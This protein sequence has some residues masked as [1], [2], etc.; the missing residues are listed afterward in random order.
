MWLRPFCLGHHLLFKRLALPF[1]EAPIA[2]SGIDNIMVG[3]L[4]CSGQSYEW[5]R[6][7]FLSGK[8]SLFVDRLSRGLCG[9]WYARKKVDLRE[10]EDLFRAYLTDGYSRPPL[11]HYESRNG[12]QLT[13]PWEVL[14]K[15]RLVQAGFSESEVL[16]G[17]LPARWYDFFT[18]KELRQLDLCSD[19]SRWRRTFFTQAEYQ[20]MH[21]EDQ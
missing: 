12:V 4:I 14:L 2:A 13:A 11:N 1:T 16:N 8:W 3:A 18:L 9:P 21:P 7:L 6:D 15:C 17:Y 5:T 19:P 10:S 20:Q